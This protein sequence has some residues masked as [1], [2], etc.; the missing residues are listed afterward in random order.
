M[1]L[2]T[3]MLAFTSLMWV[4]P[5]IA[6]FW[7]AVTFA[8]Q[9]V[10]IYLCANFFHR[11]RSESKQHDWIGMMAASELVQGVC[12]GLPLFLFWSGAN[13]LQAIYL[14]SF[15]M[16]IIAVRLLVVNNFMPVLVAGTGVMTIGVAIRCASQDEPIFLA[17]A[18]LITC[19][20]RFSFS[21]PG[22]WATRRATWSSSR[23]RRTR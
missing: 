7:L 18:G 21:S 10:Q 16:A 17:L 8:S 12:W 22:N 6:M 1:P 11:E 13:S 4:P 2:L 19:L 23:R 14:V 3:F 15:I 5:L 20:K 9:A